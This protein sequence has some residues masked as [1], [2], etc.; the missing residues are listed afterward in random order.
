MDSEGSLF[1][2]KNFLAPEWRLKTGY[3]VERGFQGSE[4]HLEIDMDSGGCI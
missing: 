1:G 3:I 2:S 4:R